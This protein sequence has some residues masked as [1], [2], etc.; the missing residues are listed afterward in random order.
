MKAFIIS[1]SKIPSSYSTA[2]I[3]KEDLK[4]SNFEVELFE[5]T[6]GNE[7]KELLIKERRTL[8]PIDHNGNETRPTFKV[9][10]PGVVG[11]FYSHYRLWKK[12]VELNEPIFIFEDDVIVIRNYI[13]V[14]F[15]EVLIVAIGSWSEIYDTDVTQDP[16]EPPIAKDFDGK[17]LPGAVG[18]GI[19]PKAAKKLIKEYSRTFTAAD[20]AVRS[21]VVNIKIHSHLIGRAKVEKD[22]KISLTKKKKW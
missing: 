22:G 10:G 20:S 2:L 3:A 16:T 7:A 1:L 15:S 13:P 9:S 5:G 18:Y 21:S 8:H 6:Y 11:C 19:T 14:E 4:K 17:C 12:C